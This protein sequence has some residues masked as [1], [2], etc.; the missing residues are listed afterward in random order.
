MSDLEMRFISFAAPSENASTTIIYFSE[1]TI[2]WGI[3]LENLT[4]NEP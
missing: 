4:V 2:I 3:V 1:F